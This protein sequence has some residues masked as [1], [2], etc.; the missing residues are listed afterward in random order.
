MLSSV[1]KRLFPSLVEG[2]DTTLLHNLQSD[3]QHCSFDLKF[4]SKEDMNT[5]MFYIMGLH[6]DKTVHLHLKMVGNDTLQVVVEHKPD[7]S[8]DLLEILV[9]DICDQANKVSAIHLPS[10]SQLPTIRL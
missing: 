3:G 2:I 6:H 1:L 4:E 10:S 9:Y 7:A 5:M 8:K